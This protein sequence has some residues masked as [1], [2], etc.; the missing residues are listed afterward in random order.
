T[1]AERHAANADV[2]LFLAH[3]DG[4]EVV[5]PARGLASKAE[6]ER[7]GYRPQWHGYAMGHEVCMEEIADVADFIRQCLA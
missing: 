3:G 6:L 5:L 2:P 1:E 4:D 7:L